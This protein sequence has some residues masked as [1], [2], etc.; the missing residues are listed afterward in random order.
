MRGLNADAGV[1]G[2]GWE[3]GLGPGLLRHGAVATDVRLDVFVVGG[4]ARWTRHRARAPHCRVVVCLP[5]VLAR[6]L[7]AP[8]GSRRRRRHRPRLGR[9]DEVPGRERGLTGT[10][11]RHRWRLF[12]PGM[13]LL[14]LL[15][16]P[17]LAVDVGVNV[18]LVVFG[19]VAGEKVGRFRHLAVV[20]GAVEG[21]RETKRL[22]RKEHTATPAAAAA[23]AGEVKRLHLRLTRPRVRTAQVARIPRGL[24]PAAASVEALDEGEILQLEEHRRLDRAPARSLRGGGRLAPL[25]LDGSTPAAAVGA[26]TSGDVRRDPT[27]SGD[28]RRDPPTTRGDGADLPA[29]GGFGVACAKEPL[30]LVLPCRSPTP[31]VDAFST[32]SPSSSSSWPSR[33][34]TD[35]DDG[36]GTSV[37]ASDAEDG[38]GASAARSLS[39]STLA[40]NIPS[41]GWSQSLSPVVKLK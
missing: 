17:L 31:S 25:R 3:D 39:A 10:T 37:M 6:R 2:G 1:V 32:S 33:L 35:T 34:A 28:V 29:L 36:V 20:Q 14:L 13:L 16:W 12:L 22:R 5:H 38:E 18:R 9:L 7:N 21:T 26:T 4:D 41:H 27:T 15:L 30:L 24:A 40:R 8:R 19:T 23:D 11:R